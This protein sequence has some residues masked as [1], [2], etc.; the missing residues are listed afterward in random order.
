MTVYRG[1]GNPDY[2]KGDGFERERPAIRKLQIPIDPPHLYRGDGYTRS[3]T[4]R[5][6]CSQ[7]RSAAI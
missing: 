4:A 7:N 5:L 3:S 2:P 6:A 1:P